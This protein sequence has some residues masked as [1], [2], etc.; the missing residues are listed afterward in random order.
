VVVYFTTPGT[1]SSSGCC[2]NRKRKKIGRVG[3]KL[4]EISEIFILCPYIVYEFK[5]IILAGLGPKLS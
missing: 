3:K 1:V 5:S 4:G 2:K